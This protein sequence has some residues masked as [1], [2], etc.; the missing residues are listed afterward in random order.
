MI[1]TI[2]GDSTRADRSILAANLAMQSTLL[3]HKVALIDI[4]SE[5]HA[6]NWGNLRGANRIKP[7]LAVFGTPGLRADLENSRSFLRTHYRDIIIDADGMDSLNTDSALIAS[8]VLVIPA[9][10]VQDGASNQEKLIQHLEDVRLFNPALRIVVVD[11]RTISAGSDAEKREIEMARNFAGAVSGASVAETVLHEQLNARRTF[12]AGL[13]V[14]DNEPINERAATEIGNLYQ[15]IV[16][17]NDLPALAPNS[18]AVSHAIQ[19][20][21]HGKLTKNVETL[22]S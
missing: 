7:K 4:T 16:K 11:V 19:R 13:S 2:F 9:R 12:D 15:E 6:L 8:H 22:T 14:F 3:H 18:L 20:Q 5:H 21:I 17:I 10:F 1:V